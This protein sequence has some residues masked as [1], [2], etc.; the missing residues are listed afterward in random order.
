MERI[1]KQN[2]MRSFFSQYGEVQDFPMSL[3]FIKPEVLEKQ[4]SFSHMPSSGRVLI[5]FFQ[6]LKAKINYKKTKLCDNFGKW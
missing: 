3:I 6:T 5:R 2:I 1:I 4:F